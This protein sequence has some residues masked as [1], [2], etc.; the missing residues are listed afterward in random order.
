VNVVNSSTPCRYR[1][2]HTLTDTWCNVLLQLVLQ[3]HRRLQKPV[4]DIM[5][6]TINCCNVS[7]KYFWLY[8][9]LYAIMLCATCFTMPFETCCRE[10]STVYP[11]PRL[12]FFSINIFVQQ[13]NLKK[14]VELNADPACMDYILRLYINRILIRP[15]RW[16]IA[17]VA[18][19]VT[20]VQGVYTRIK[21]FALRL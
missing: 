12:R 18:I 14:N 16:W 7:Y 21:S 17:T 10:Y 15:A 20:S 5:S 2:S 13:T 9:S 6:T 1:V 8:S 19:Q 11:C 4:H 3:L